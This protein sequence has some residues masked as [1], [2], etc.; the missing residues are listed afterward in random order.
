MVAGREVKLCR[1]AHAAANHVFAVVGADRA[2]R[3]RQVG[4]APHDIVKLFLFNR[5][6]FQFNLQFFA[7]GFAFGDDCRTF[8]RG[9]GFDRIAQPVLFFGQRLRRGF[10]LVD[11]QMQ[12]DQ[13]GNVDGQTFFG[14]AFFH[15]FLIFDNEFYI[16]HFT[17]P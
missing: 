2:F 13:G 16:Q 4:H 8:F 11:V 1:L 15:Q 3:A 7:E 6:F 10:Q 17:C 5:Q 12:G 14:N 9:S